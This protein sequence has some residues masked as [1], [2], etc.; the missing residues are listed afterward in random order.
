MS[1]EKVKDC[2][3]CP[4]PRSPTTRKWNNFCSHLNPTYLY[5]Q[6]NPWKLVPICVNCDICLFLGP[7]SP[8][9]A[10][11]GS[12]PL[13]FGGAQRSLNLLQQHNVFEPLPFVQVHSYIFPD[14]CGVGRV[15]IIRW[16]FVDFAF[17]LV[18][19]RIHLAMT[20]APAVSLR[21]GLPRIPRILLPHWAAVRTHAITIL[22]V[23]KVV[24]VWCF[25]CLFSKQFWP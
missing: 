23:H 5:S 24:F 13:V 8:S 7:K 21:R 10:C 16:I 4:S 14:L 9:A 12:G 18:R 11:G 3:K 1:F 19:L 25:I 17:V 6:C 2:I 20:E 15:S 22:T